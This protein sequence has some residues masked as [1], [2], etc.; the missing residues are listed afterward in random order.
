LGVAK[1]DRN[2]LRAG[3]AAQRARKLRHQATYP[4]RKL[5]QILRNRQ[6][7]G[8]KFRRQYP[9]GPY[10]AD[11]CCTEAKLIVEVDGNSHIGRRTVDLTRHRWLERQGMTVMRVTNDQ[12]LRD[13]EG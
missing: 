3:G 1:D 11:F 8:L 6:I 4:E 9:I 5:W 13:E 2:R 10:V 12:V 7:A